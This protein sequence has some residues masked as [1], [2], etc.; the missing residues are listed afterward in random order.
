LLCSKLGQQLSTEHFPV[1]PMEITFMDMEDKHQ[2]NG[3]LRSLRYLYSNQFRILISFLGLLIFFLEIA[4]RERLAKML[5]MTAH[6]TDSI[7]THK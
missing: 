5:P 1:M 7:V 3:N 4:K 2:K 6:Q